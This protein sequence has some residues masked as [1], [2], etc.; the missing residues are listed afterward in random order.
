MRSALAIPVPPSRNPWRGKGLAVTAALLVHPGRRW[1]LGELAGAAGASKAM[2]SRVVRELVRLG[3]VDGDLHQGRAASLI[4]RRDLARRAGAN[5]PD[6]VAYI[7]GAAPDGFPLGGGPAQ[8]AAGLL[9]VSRTRVYLRS[10]EDA[11]RV[12]G[13]SGGALVSEPVADWELAVLDLD[14]PAGPLPAP[15]AAAEL[16]RTPR[17]RETVESHPELLSGFPP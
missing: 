2:A 5:W 6:P 9:P 11:P 1:R 10:V 16:C 4:A 3:V 14:L 17:G 7:A 8:E 15:L 12:L 13:L